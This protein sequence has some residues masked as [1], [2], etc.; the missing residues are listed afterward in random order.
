MLFNNFDFLG[1]VK[2]SLV[3]LNIT[4][5]DEVKS[6]DIDGILSQFGDR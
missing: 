6:K 5:P 1:F 4:F 2:L 3:T